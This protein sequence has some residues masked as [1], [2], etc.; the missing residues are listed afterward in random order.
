[1]INFLLKK[2]GFVHGI[3]NTDNM[4]ILGLTLDYGPYEFI[5]KFDKKTTANYSDTV[6][7]YC[8]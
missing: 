3:L 7:K 4:S 5:E 2:L 8:Y 6:E 1:M